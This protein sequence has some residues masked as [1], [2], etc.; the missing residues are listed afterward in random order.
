MNPRRLPVLLLP[1]LT[2]SALV[3]APRDGRLFDPGVAM[4]EP[5]PNAPEEVGLL[6][7]LVG[8]YAVTYRTYAD[9]EEVHA[10]EGVSE[11]RF[12]NRGWAYFERFHCPAAD[13]T[14]EDLEEIVFT[15]FTPSTGSWVMGAANSLTSAITIH[16][17]TV[18][19]EG[20]DLRDVRRVGGGAVLTHSRITG[21]MTPDGPV[22]VRELSTDGGTTWARSW[23]KEYRRVAERP[24][25]LDTRDDH[26]QPHPDLSPEARAFD[27]LVGEWAE[28]HV[29]QR[30]GGP[31]QFP[32]NGT[33]V[34]CLDGRGILEYSW[35]DVDP[36]FPDAATSIVRL[37]NPASRRWE[38]MYTTNRFNGILHFGGVEEGERIVLHR[39]D[40]DRTT[41]PINYWIFSEREADSYFWHAL[42][43]ADRGATWDTTWTI[44]GTRKAAD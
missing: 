5:S 29:L 10:A 19:A 27:F 38:S 30:P 22:V 35:M 12:L 11:I 26:G 36:N 2:V 17:G 21:S 33:A 34:Y 23:A 32:S 15:A 14:G 8:D 43:S 39:F 1:L 40:V 37:W 3:A 42:T 6:A 9:G 4:E 16:T 18:D 7:P 13:T 25:A 20:M 31:V 28:W 44:A 24:V 41:P